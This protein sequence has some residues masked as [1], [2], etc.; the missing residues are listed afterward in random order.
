[1]SF[2]KVIYDRRIRFVITVFNTRLPKSRLCR[3][4]RTV[5]KFVVIDQISCA[6]IAGFANKKLK[7]KLVQNHRD[8][9]LFS[10]QFIARL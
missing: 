5:Q 10:I 9:F 1:M 4:S 2:C 6:K 8:L 7:S 3:N